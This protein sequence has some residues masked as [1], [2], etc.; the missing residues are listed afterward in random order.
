MPYPTKDS[1][2]E[3]VKKLPSH[4]IDIWKGAFNSAYEQ[5]KSESKAFA[6]AWAAVEKAGYSKNAAGEW[7]LMHPDHQNM[8]RMYA[9]ATD[10]DKKAQ[11]ER[12]KKYHIGIKDNGNVAKPGKYSDVPDE[13]FLDPVNYSYPVQDAEHV[14]AAARYWGKAE[15]K[16]IYSQSEQTIIDTRLAAA[17]SK[18]K[19]SSK[20]SC[21]TFVATATGTR[22]GSVWEVR[23]IKEGKDANKVYWPPEVL[24]KDSGIFEGAK[25]FMLDEGQHSEKAN[26]YG[27]PTNALVGWMSAVEYKN[28]GTYALFNFAATNKG[29]ELQ[30]ALNDAWN[31]GK[32]DLFAFSV[33][34]SGTGEMRLIDGEEL[35]TVTSIAKGTVDIVYD[36][37]AG[38]EFIRMVA[39]KNKGVKMDI[40]ELL[41]KLKVSRPDIYEANKEK[42]DLKT[43]TIDDVVAWSA[44]PK[45]KE[46]KVDQTPPSPDIIKALDEVRVITAQLTLER[47]LSVS[48]LPQQTQ[49]KL[50]SLYSG[51]IFKE[52]ELKTAIKDEKEYLDKVTG[53]LVKSSGYIKVTSDDFD[54]R[55]KAF[56]DFF[57]GKFAS[58]RAAYINF[59]GD[60][61][62]TG[63]IQN[64]KRFT[65]SMDTTSLSNVLQDS[66]RKKLVEEYKNSP[67]DQSWMQ[68][69]DISPIADFRTNHRTRYGGYGNLQSVAQGA[70]Y[71]SLASPTDEEATYSVGKYG[72]TEDITFELV[73][74][75]ESGV[76]R[77][78]PQKLGVAASRT[79]YEFIYDTFQTNPTIYDA[80]ALFH[81]SHGNLSTVAFSA[82]ELKAVRLRMIKQTERD[83]SK[84]L[85]ILPKVVLN[86]VDLQT[87]VEEALYKPAGDFLPSSPDFVRR[88]TMTNINVVHWT[89]ATNWYTVADPKT[90]LGIEVGFLDDQRDPEIFVQD[91]PTV[92]SVFTHDKITFKIRHIYGQVVRDYRAFQGNV[93]AG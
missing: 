43:A 51:K 65:A 83:S 81:A 35:L 73:K 50:R 57:D 92:G 33:D 63:R 27:K 49:D 14:R 44:L 25:V 67:Y 23:I 87:T 90:I 41:A 37:A 40:E 30:T 71:P 45:D 9:A 8:N 77:R 88:Q 29:K 85:G 60:E 58:F 31:K 12:S 6:V 15:N 91:S 64:C 24:Q 2:P 75:D 47:N 48:N 62:V 10:A 7:I 61:L 26:K 19:I 3:A 21:E 78:I 36:P 79:I 93:V 46:K 32:K 54:N 28:N 38:G 13:M 56:D 82:T 72:G 4:A 69:V 39:C 20:T 76:I 53:E 84:R 68:I 74:N 16:A 11:E 86:P 22:I 34:V 52:E 89:D 17:E 66:M 59:T 42:F 18:F 80:V 70:P 55:K 1:L 5:Y